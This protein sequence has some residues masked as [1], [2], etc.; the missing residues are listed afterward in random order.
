VENESRGFEVQ[1]SED[2]LHFDKIGWV[3]SKGVGGAGAAY[4]LKDVRVQPGVTYYYRLKHVDLD[5]TSSLSEVREAI[6]PEN[7]RIVIL[8]SYPNPIENDLFVEFEIADGAKMSF[9]VVSV[10]GQELGIRQEMELDPGAHKVALRMNEVAA[11][12]YFLRIS[13][14]GQPV[15]AIKFFKVR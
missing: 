7:D 8:T 3:D 10:T 4:E 11:G 1:R 12:M 15:G 5:G 9:D 6:L 14:D 2:G 13:M